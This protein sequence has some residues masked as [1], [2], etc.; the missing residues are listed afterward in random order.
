MVFYLFFIPPLCLLKEY[1][2]FI[3][4]SLFQ[5]WIPWWA[6]WHEEG[7]TLNAYN[8]GRIPVTHYKMRHL[9]SIWSLMSLC[10]SLDFIECRFTYFHSIIVCTNTRLSQY[11]WHGP[12]AAPERVEFVECPVHFLPSLMKI[13]SHHALQKRSMLF[14]NFFLQKAYWI[15]LTTSTT[16]TVRLSTW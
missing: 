10:A 15:R 1:D 7:T 13:T 5:H 6:D 3:V 4:T 12:D 16:E 8:C 11:L 9:W 2:I 14:I